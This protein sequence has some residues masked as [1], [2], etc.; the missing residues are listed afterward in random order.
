MKTLNEAPLP[1]DQNVDP[2][3]TDQ[4]EPAPAPD[5]AVAAA[6]PAMTVRV[7]IEALQQP[8]EKD[9]MIDPVAGDILDGHFEAK[10]VS[11]DGKTAEIQITAVNGKPLRGDTAGDDAGGEPP[12][13]DAAG[14]QPKPDN[15]GD[16]EEMA[17][18]L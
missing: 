12:A 13:D 7:P 4:N 1:D 10:V 8:D 16:L 11:S 17:K 5:D 18:R 6:G 2:G 14:E 9:Q 3:L 15:Y